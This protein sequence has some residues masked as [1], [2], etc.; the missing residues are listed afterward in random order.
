[1]SRLS[2]HHQELNAEGIGKCSV[3]MWSGGCPA[4]FCDMDAYGE[5]VNNR[6]DGYVP[7]LACPI[8]GGP[9]TRVFKDGN[10]WVAVHPDFQNLQESPAGFGDTPEEA[11]K[12]LVSA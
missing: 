11:R 2:N 8:H 5:R 3:P 7:A 6:Y 4:G 12:A 1:M 10:A 9:T